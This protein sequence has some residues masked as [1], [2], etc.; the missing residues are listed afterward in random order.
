M[1]LIQN[2][3]KTQCYRRLQEIVS[4]MMAGTSVDDFTNMISISV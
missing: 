2:C 3:E 4:S 1:I